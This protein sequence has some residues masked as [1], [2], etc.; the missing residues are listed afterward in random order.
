M[1]FRIFMV[2]IFIY[3]LYSEWGYKPMGGTSHCI[4]AWFGEKS[5]NITN[6]GWY[7][8]N[9]WFLVGFVGIS[10]YILQTW[11]ILTNEN[12]GLG[13][14]PKNIWSV[15]GSAGLYY[16]WL[17][18]VLYG[19]SEF[20][21]RKSGFQPICGRKCRRV[22][23]TVPSSIQRFSS[24]FLKISGIPCWDSIRDQLLPLH[25][26]ILN[27]RTHQKNIRKHTLLVIKHGLLEN[28]PFSS[29]I[30]PAINLHL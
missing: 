26:Q 6:Q 23:G 4:I 8:W 12:V 2:G 9:P 1:C 14:W 30:F 29:M 25:S 27:L 10:W 18:L 7:P 15:H 17:N 13:S 22:S 20:T 21:N 16:I 3:L 5:R 11:G 28:P 24:P 19:L